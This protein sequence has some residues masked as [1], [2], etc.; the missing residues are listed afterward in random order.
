MS[1]RSQSR[2]GRGK[3]REEEPRSERDVV[4]RARDELK[5]G[6]SPKTAAGEFVHQEI[7]PVREGKHGA[8]NPKLAIATG[9]SRARRAGIP[10]GPPP[11]G[12]GK[13]KS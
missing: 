5:R 4:E 3:H 10:L 9:L 12:K 11:S 1:G 7:R 13:S 2:R 6:Y 8:K